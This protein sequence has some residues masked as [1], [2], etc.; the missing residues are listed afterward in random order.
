MFRVQGFIT[1]NIK[2]RIINV[3]YRRNEF[4]LI[5]K[6]IEQR[7]TTLRHSK[8]KILRFCGSLFNF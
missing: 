2:Y 1:A 5:Y 3:E 4:Y 7:E 6:K 8:F